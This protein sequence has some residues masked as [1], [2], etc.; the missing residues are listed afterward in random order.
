MTTPILRAMSQVRIGKPSEPPKI[1][2][3]QQQQQQQL[4][5]ERAPAEEAVGVR[6]GFNV[7]MINTSQDVFW[8]V[9]PSERERAIERPITRRRMVSPPG[10]E[11]SD[12]SCIATSS[13][14]D[15]LR[16]AAC[17]HDDPHRTQHA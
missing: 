15:L 10:L 11:V 4:E 6:E 3:G 14:S 7:P 17:M 5:E 16:C 8:Y 12:I 13:V 9:A 1:F 2:P